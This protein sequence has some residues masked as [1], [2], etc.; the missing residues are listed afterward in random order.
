[1]G[2][3]ISVGLGV[4]TGV[5]MKVGTGISVGSGVKVGANVGV[6]VGSG[7]RVGS[8]VGDG[9]G[10][11][12]GVGSVCGAGLGRAVASPEGTG[13]A[14]NASVGSAVTAGEGAGVQDAPG[15][16]LGG[17]VKSAYCDGLGVPIKPSVG[18]GE[19]KTV[20]SSGFLPNIRPRSTAEITAAAA[21]AAAKKRYP[22]RFS[23]AAFFSASNRAASETKPSS[24]SVIERKTLNLSSFFICVCPRFQDIL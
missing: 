12:V 15:L 13:G 19:P 6:S 21:N 23:R 1:M 10:H 17:S 14:V 5:G 7:G 4:G 8:C 20:L 2:V 3:G 24:I 18:A 22:A 9:V 11:A 16:V